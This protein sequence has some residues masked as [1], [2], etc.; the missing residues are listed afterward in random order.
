MR[1]FSVLTRSSVPLL[2]ASLLLGACA[3]QPMYPGV[4]PPAGSPSHSKALQNVSVMDFG[5]V[6]NDGVDDTNAFQQAVNTARNVYV[7]AGDFDVSATIH[8][9]TDTRLYGSGHASRL[10]VTSPAVNQVIRAGNSTAGVSDVVVE[11]LSIEP[12]TH[13]QTLDLH[14]YAIIT[15]HGT[16]VSIRNNRVTAMGGIAVD[17]SADVQVTGNVVDGA[18]HLVSPGGVLVFGYN[19]PGVLF[20]PTRNVTV[21]GNNV[22]NVASGIYWFGGWGDPRKEGFSRASAVEYVTIE[23]NTVSTTESGIWG[24][25]GAHITV[26]GN[27]VQV[28]SD[29][30]LDAEGSHHVRFAD[31]TARHAGSGVLSVFFFSSDVVFENNTVEQDGRSWPGHWEDP[32]GVAGHKMFFSDNPSSDP[33]SI[34]IFLR[35]NRFT[36]TGSSSAGIGVGL[37]HKGSARLVEIDRNTFSNTVF[38]MMANN[39][40]SV[41]ITNNELS[42]TANAR[43]RAMHVGYNHNAP[44]DQVAGYAHVAGNRVTS[45]AAQDQ[46]AIEVHQGAWGLALTS[47]IEN[48]TIRGFPT[49]IRYK[50]E[51]QAHNWRIVGNTTDGIWENASTWAPNIEIRNN[52]I[53]IHSWYKYEDRLWGH[54]PN[55]GYAGGYEFS[56]P[57][58]FYVVGRASSSAY[59]QIFRCRMSASP[60]RHF[61]TT[62]AS[63]NGDYWAMRETLGGMYGIRPGYQGSFPGVVPLYRLHYPW[64]GDIYFTADET[65][66]NQIVADG[67]QVQGIIAYVWR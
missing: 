12:V 1:H 18:S 60:Y 67:W 43:R 4:S 42:F 62:S 61:L 13:P 50:N 56:R 64:N 52:G 47:T 23:S 35:N 46:A 16:R 66:K 40:G 34:T 59:V 28:C 22:R 3:D 38:E 58:W 49:A 9:P 44:W 19:D 17:K 54:D 31:N 2:A 53:G 33:D 63:C 29:V 51:N 65:E 7:P 8:L 30:C 21:R 39:S 37:V 41:R 14:R 6:A 11:D 45:W 20:I 5:A 36:Y 55:E 27:D 48:N 24:S 25:N 10:R 32:S 15:E 26:T 57:N